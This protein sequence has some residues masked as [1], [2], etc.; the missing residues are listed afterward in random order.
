MGNPLAV[1]KALTVHGAQGIT[2]GPGKPVERIC[3]RCTFRALLDVEMLKTVMLL[4]F[5][6]QFCIG[7]RKTHPEARWPGQVLSVCCFEACAYYWCF[8]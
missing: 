3:V 4:L 5:V 6:L 1:S 2:S 7:R 8:F